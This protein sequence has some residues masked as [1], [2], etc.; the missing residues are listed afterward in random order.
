MPASGYFHRLLAGIRKKKRVPVKLE[1]WMMSVKDSC[2]TANKGLSK[3]RAAEQEKKETSGS[4][5]ISGREI[6][7]A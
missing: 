1:P 7:L 3:E 5:F 4:S 2:S 6:P